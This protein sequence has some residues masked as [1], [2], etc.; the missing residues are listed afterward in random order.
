MNAGM[1]PQMDGFLSK[2]GALTSEERAQVLRHPGESAALLRRAGV[3]DEEWIDCVLLHHERDDGSGYP[4]GRR[5][6][7]IPRSARLIGMADRYC[8]CVSARNYR[9]SMLAPVALRAVCGEHELA[10]DA[11]LAPHF[12]AQLG[13]YPPGTRV[14]LAN[15]EIGVVSR[16]CD[17]QGAQ[18]VHALRTA[19]GEMLARPEPRQTGPMHH[20]IEEA[21]HEDQVAIRFSM[22]HIWGELASL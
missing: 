17:A 7:R 3:T 8:A 5:A 22:K 18:V 4:E 6:D 15:G 14:R 2:A 9:R 1:M 16:R 21:L 20:A 13:H 11:E 12:V 19:A 10:T